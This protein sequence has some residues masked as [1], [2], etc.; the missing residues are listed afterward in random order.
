M[1][2]KTKCVAQCHRVVR[3]H[4]KSLMGRS[5]AAHSPNGRFADG[6]KA[7]NDSN[8]SLSINKLCFFHRHA[9][10]AGAKA[11]NSKPLSRIEVRHIAREHCA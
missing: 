10:A 5:F 6:A 7:W 11:I 1:Q 2:L 3:A 4:R 9:S 8:V